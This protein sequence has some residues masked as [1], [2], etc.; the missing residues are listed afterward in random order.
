VRRLI[1]IAVAGFVVA[2][3]LNSNYDGIR[4]FAQEQLDRT[5]TPDGPEVEGTEAPLEDVHG[6]AGLGGLWHRDNYGRNHE[7]LTCTATDFSL[8]CSYEQQPASGADDQSEQVDPAEGSFI[9]AFIDP[10][11]CPAH[12]S[13]PCASAV[14]ITQ[15]TASFT[16]G[17]QTE[18]TITLQGDD[19]MI[20][21]WDTPGLYGSPFHCPWYATYEIALSRPHDC[22]FFG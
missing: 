1:A 17:I 2:T 11:D 5:A 19:S 8:R 20:L 4:D 7:V 3:V 6:R 16:S 12:M 9:G 13:G 10:Q 22:T 14:E 15:G 21:S 18:Q